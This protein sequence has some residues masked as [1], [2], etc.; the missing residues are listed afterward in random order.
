MSDIFNIFPFFFLNFY[1]KTI[2]KA[3]V[4]LRVG[5][6]RPFPGACR[7]EKNGSQFP[8]RP[9]TLLPE[10]GHF[11]LCY[12]LWDEAGRYEEPFAQLYTVPHL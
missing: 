10:I 4:A 6:C 2:K 1:V 9:L 8:T 5:C 3:V 12:V 7:I 11:V